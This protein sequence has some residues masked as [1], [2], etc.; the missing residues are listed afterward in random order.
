[1]LRIH[2]Y[3][4]L[5]YAVQLSKF[6]S[7]F[8]VMYNYYQIMLIKIFLKHFIMPMQFPIVITWEKMEDSLVDDSPPTYWYLQSNSPLP[9]RSFL[10]ASSCMFFKIS[11]RNMNFFYI[12]KFGYIALIM[13]NPSNS[14]W[15]LICAWLWIGCDKI[16]YTQTKWNQPWTVFEL[17]Y[18]IVASG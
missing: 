16:V 18:L 10:L 6:V 15:Y 9:V 14:M 12:L 8:M 4:Q 3:M 17:V 2:V 5:C 13:L 11:C 7:L 1:M